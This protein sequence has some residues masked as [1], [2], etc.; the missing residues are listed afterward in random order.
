MERPLSFPL[1]HPRGLF[2]QA[3]LDRE[4]RQAKQTLWSRVHAALGRR[5]VD[6]REGDP[7]EG[8]R[9]GAPGAEVPKYLVR[10]PLSPEAQAA[11]VAGA[12]KDGKKRYCLPF[13]CH[14]G[15]QRR[16]CSEFRAP[17]LM[18]D[19]RALPWETRA[20]MMRFG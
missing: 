9:A 18:E 13:N 12:P 14:G 1:G 8:A 4:E 20:V 3:M 5:P 10:E 16:K 11:G 6:A 19:V 15:C 7:R 17:I 2:Q